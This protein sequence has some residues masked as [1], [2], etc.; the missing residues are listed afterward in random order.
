MNKRQVSHTE[1]IH[2]TLLGARRKKKRV[3]LLDELSLLALVFDIGGL[4]RMKHRDI[5]GRGRERNTR[6]YL[7][8]YLAH[9]I[10]VK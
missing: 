8:V 6:D 3:S 2:S 1:F 4:S 7:R 5:W 9:V 10:D